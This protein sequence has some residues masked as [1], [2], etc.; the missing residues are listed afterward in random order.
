MALNAAG[1]V[2]AA[3]VGAT[4]NGIP[5]SVLVLQLGALAGLTKSAITVFRE[6][7]LTYSV[8]VVFT[9]LLFLIASSFGICP[10]LVTEVG[11]IALGSTPKELV[12]SAVVAAFPL[13]FETIRDLWPK[14][15]EEGKVDYFRWK[16]SIFLVGS[17][18]LGGYVFARM[19]ANQGMPISN[20]HAACS[21]GAVYG[22][23]TFLA[24]TITGIMAV[25]RTSSGKTYKDIF[26][27]WELVQPETIQMPR[28]EHN[29]MR[30]S[31]AASYTHI[32][33][34]LL[35]ILDSMMRTMSRCF[36]CCSSRQEYEEFR[37]SEGDHATETALMGGFFMAERHMPAATA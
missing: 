2:A 3:R 25:C 8:N 19:A 9:V 1:G 13:V 4:L 34:R 7:V 29:A 22:T 32:I 24:R 16:W 28:E 26:G 10:L 21:A 23:L 11:N 30:Q 18:A 36:C 5:P 33:G 14:P 15:D 20:Y 12:I 31:L 37:R 6:V 35:G 27:V 17:N